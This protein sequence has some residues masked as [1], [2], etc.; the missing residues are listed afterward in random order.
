MKL[1]SSLLASS[2]VFRRA[3]ASKYPVEILNCHLTT[4][5]DKSPERVIV[6]SSGALE[7]MLAMGLED[8]I[9]ASCWV[10]EVWK[11]LTPGFSKFK[12]YP[13]YP[14]HMEMVALDPDFIYATYSSA[15]DVSRINYT[16][17]LDIAACELV[18]ASN[19]YGQN[20]TYCRQE[21]HDAGIGTFL[22]T[23]YC[24]LVEVCFV[25]SIRLTVGAFKTMTSLFCPASA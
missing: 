3:S 20:K 14:N 22:S 13:K 5:V 12:H 15:F 10:K 24:E 2:F 7:I 17:A 9:V 8:K 16:E 21:L 18:I 1:S 25:S 11:P 23:G 6:A 4:T 19:V